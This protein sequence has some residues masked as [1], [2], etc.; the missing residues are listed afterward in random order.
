MYCIHTPIGNAYT[1]TYTYIY[2]T[3]IYLAVSHILYG[4]FIYYRQILGG[5]HAYYIYMCV[6]K[7]I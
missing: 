3:A 2:I 6:Y 1:D 5:L 7:A 4:Y